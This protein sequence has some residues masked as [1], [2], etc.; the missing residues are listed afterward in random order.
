MKLY[1][2]ATAL[3]LSQTTFAASALSIAKL[4]CT[5]VNAGGFASLKLSP[6]GQVEIVVNNVFKSEAKLVSLSESS[7]LF[8]QANS[9]SQYR[10]EFPEALKA[11]D[12]KVQG[13]LYSKYTPSAAWLATSYAT[14][15]IT[16]A[17]VAH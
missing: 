2:F 8:Q 10:I 5:A 16:A 9:T 11:G 17:E 15:Q 1:A 13:I 4:D 6:S 7:V 14:C 3:L 12:Q